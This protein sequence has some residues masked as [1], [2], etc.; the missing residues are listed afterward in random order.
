M[1]EDPVVP[2]TPENEKGAT[3]AIQDAGD[4]PSLAIVN[5]DIGSDTS[6]GMYGDM[7]SN[8][9]S[10]SAIYC[11]MAPAGGTGPPYYWLY[12]LAEGAA[13]VVFS[14]HPA[15]AVDAR[16]PGTLVLIQDAGGR[17]VDLRGH[18]LRV[19]KDNKNTRSGAEIKRDYEILIRPLFEDDDDGYDFASHLPELDP[20]QLDSLV[21][22][23]LNRQV[24][25][26]IYRQQIGTIPTNMGRM[27]NMALLMADMSSVPQ[28]AFSIEIKPKWLSQSPNAI[29]NALRCRTCALQASKG[30]APSDYI[31]PL[32]LGLGARKIIEPWLKRKVRKTIEIE[33]FALEPPP[34]VE[35]KIVE[36]LTTY[37]AAGGEGHELLKH[38][39]HLQTKHDPKGVL[40]CDEATVRRADRLTKRY[41]EQHDHDELTSPRISDL[42]S[43]LRTTEGNQPGK[44][45]DDFTDQ[46][47]D[48]FTKIHNLQHAMTLRDCS[49]FIKVNYNSGDITVE[50]KLGDL[51]FKSKAKLED[52]REKEE[53]LISGGWYKGFGTFQKSEPCLLTASWRANIPW[54]W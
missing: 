9:F 52:W 47:I 7:Y 45:D 36:H 17:P 35:Q 8:K 6:P 15:T 19:S 39:R 46:E 11:H 26:Q 3:A 44:S 51:D 48:A 1:I 34:G 29:P 53:D 49:L 2:Q 50:S 13:N 21:I 16:T 12:F 42:R 30:G 38:L 27:N 23:D 40:S 10:D 18:V 20:I 31:C 28:E 32:Q 54:Y 25:K 14:I 5:L 4:A 37:L 33:E 41:Q 24:S 22:V 43:T